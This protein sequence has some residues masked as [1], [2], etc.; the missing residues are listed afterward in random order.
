MLVA[1]VLKHHLVVSF[2]ALPHPATTSNK[3]RTMQPSP[4]NRSP[5]LLSP[6]GAATLLAVASDKP[7]PKRAQRHCNIVPVLIVLSSKA[8]GHQA[9]LC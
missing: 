5:V 9:Q 7:T 1:M 8:A 4:Y 2:R 3:S 6:L